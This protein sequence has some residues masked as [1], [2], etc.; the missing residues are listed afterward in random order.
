MLVTH[1]GVQKPHC[2]PLVF[3]SRS[4]TGSSPSRTLP[5]PAESHQVYGVNAGV[6]GLNGAFVHGSSPSTEGPPSTYTTGVA[7]HSDRPHSR[8]AVRTFDRDDGTAIARAEGSE[9][10]VDGRP[11]GRPLPRIVGPQHHGARPTAP[12]AAPDLPRWEGS[13]GVSQHR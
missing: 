12:L 7:I 3:T 8:Q 10:R 5:T 2:V 9:A 11:M 6:T 13:P 4:C 1:P